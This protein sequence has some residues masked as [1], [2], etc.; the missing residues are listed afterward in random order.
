[1][2][3]ISEKIVF[4]KAIF[5]FLKVRLN[6]ADAFAA[7]CDMDSWIIKLASL[8]ENSS[9]GMGTLAA[10][11]L[12]FE[13]LEND[14]D[15]WLLEDEQTQES[16]NLSDEGKEE[17]TT[18]NSALKRNH[19]T[20]QPETSIRELQSMN[21]GIPDYPQPNNGKRARTEASTMED[22]NMQELNHALPPSGNSQ[23][24]S[25]TFHDSDEG[26]RDSSSSNDEDPDADK[27]AIVTVESTKYQSRSQLPASDKSE[28]EII[29][30]SDEETPISKVNE[31]YS[32]VDC[33]Y[34]E[35]VDDEYDDKEISQDLEVDDEMEDE[36]EYV[37]SHDSKVEGHRVRES[38]SLSDAPDAD[39]TSERDTQSSSKSASDEDEV[40]EI[41]SGNKVHESCIVQQE[42]SVRESSSN[43]MKDYM[44]GDDDGLAT[45]QFNDQQPLTLM[46][47]KPDFTLLRRDR[48]MNLASTVS[49]GPDLRAGSLGSSSHEHIPFG[50]E[51]DFTDMVCSVCQQNMDAENKSQNSAA[52]MVGPMELDESQETDLAV[53]DDDSI[54]TSKDNAP[55]KVSLTQL[56]AECKTVVPLKSIEH[57]LSPLPTVNEETDLNGCV[58]QPAHSEDTDA[59][60]KTNIS[61]DSTHGLEGKPENI[62]QNSI[63]NEQTIKD[64]HQVDETSV[65][66]QGSTCISQ[67]SPKVL[68]TKG[69]AAEDQKDDDSVMDSRIGRPMSKAARSKANEDFLIPSMSHLPRPRRLAVETPT[70]SETNRRQR[71]NSNKVSN[72]SDIFHSRPVQ[73]K[74][75]LHIKTS[76]SAT[77]SVRI[78]A[79]SRSK[80]GCGCQAG[81]KTLKCSCKMTGHVCT[82]KCGCMG[83]CEGNANPQIVHANAKSH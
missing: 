39:Q 76:P 51:T 46:I 37:R 6:T 60:T 61:D 83:M 48:E 71:S 63:T 24:T 1:L 12:F 15:E 17:A 40:V 66:S 53:A 64:E 77:V 29:D 55:I 82:K 43:N 8:S 11:D 27:G 58:K 28:I 35:K 52:S 47:K 14:P 59:F 80:K 22:S 44:S 7:A 81:C 3:I 4:Q 31:K 38:P 62:D 72:V 33:S 32:S 18:I 65:K 56:N 21:L 42:K 78:M 13:S 49:H 67:K 74:Q 36:E 26:N 54:S 73:S 69:T 45:S 68:I 57:K 79:K 30:S 50:D 16:S 10:C 2:F 19:G 75:N 70:P 34:E 41:N 25:T 9:P 20:V 5:D 23:N